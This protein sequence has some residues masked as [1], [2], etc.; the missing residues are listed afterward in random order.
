MWIIKKIMAENFSQYQ[1]M[2]SISLMY[3]C[4]RVPRHQRNQFW[5]LGEDND[6][7]EVGNAFNG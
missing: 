6:A 3:H 1:N 4:L 2:K 7:K 5:V